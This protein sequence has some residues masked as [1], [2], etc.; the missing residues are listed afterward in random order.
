MPRIEASFPVDT[1]GILDVSVK[2][3]ATQ[4]S[5][6]IRITGSTRLPEAKEQCMFDQAERTLAD[7]AAKLADDLRRR[8]ATAPREALG[9]RDVGLA[10]Q[11]A[12]ALRA[13]LQEPG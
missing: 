10:A 12:D 13:L 11:N 4:T 1:D 3:T 8:I 2:Q 5:W 7:F 9:K 6:S